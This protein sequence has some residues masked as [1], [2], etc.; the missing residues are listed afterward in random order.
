MF[1]SD[2]LT[3]ILWI[4]QI[5]RL[6]SAKL[7]DVPISNGDAQLD[8]ELIPNIVVSGLVA[9]LYL[10]LPMMLPNISASMSVTVIM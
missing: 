8:P 10:M 1:W 2:T 5:C 4:P 9:L 3:G 6:R 7:L